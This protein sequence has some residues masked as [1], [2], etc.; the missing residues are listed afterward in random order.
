MLAAFSEHLKLVVLM[1]LHGVFSFAHDHVHDMVAGKFFLN[2]FYC[3]KNR[4]NFLLSV[5]FLFRM[6]T[7]ITAS[8]VVLVVMFAEI[9]Q[10]HLSAAHTCFSK[11]DS[12]QDELL[13][14]FL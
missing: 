9:I 12:F 14:N 7:I 3:F 2:S 10:Q 4:L 6:Q 11:T 13:A 5:K 8:A 1:K